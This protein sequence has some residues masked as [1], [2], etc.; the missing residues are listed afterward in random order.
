M[1]NNPMPD[2]ALAELDRLFADLRG[3]ELIV[4]EQ[5]DDGFA[6]IN[7]RGVCLATTMFSGDARFFARIYSQYP[8]LRQRL[9]DAESRLAEVDSEGGREWI[10]E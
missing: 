8:A 2:A 5:M 9:L 1:P 3:G 4:Q 7:E 10:A 6:L